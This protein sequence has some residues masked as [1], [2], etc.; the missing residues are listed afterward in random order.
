MILYFNK[1]LEFSY[2][3]SS[4]INFDNLYLTPCHITKVSYLFYFF[5]QVMA[6]V[7]GKKKFG[8]GGLL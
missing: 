2:S 3:V 5:N 7:L 6:S 4:A 1:I 8:L